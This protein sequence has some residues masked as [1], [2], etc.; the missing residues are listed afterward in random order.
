MTRCVDSRIGKT[1]FVTENELVHTRAG[2][3]PRQLSKNRLCS[4]PLVAI[5]F[6]CLTGCEGSAD[7]RYSTLAADSLLKELADVHSLEAPTDRELS[8]TDTT[9]ATTVSEY[10]ARYLVTRLAFSC[11]TVRW[12]ATVERGEETW[13][14]TQE[15]VVA[16]SGETK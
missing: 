2:H 8:C 13:L 3:I 1:A 12:D 9:G 4:V 5:V 6:A 15:A 14:A 11:S 16:W 7:Y 10:T